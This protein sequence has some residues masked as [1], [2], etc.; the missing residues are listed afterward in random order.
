MQRYFI[1]ENQINNDI[2]TITNE[3]VHHI[4]TVMRMRLDDKIIAVMDNKLFQCQLINIGS[5]VEAK[6]IEEISENNELSVNVT[7]AQGLVRREKTEEVIRRI[8]ELGASNYIPVDMKRSVVKVKEGKVDR[9]NKIIKEASEQSHRNRLMNVSDVINLKEL[10]KEKPKY[11]LCLFAHVDQNK[12]PIE[13]Y[14]NEFLG[15]N[16][17]ILV[18]PEGGFDPTEVKLLLNNGFFMVSLGNLILRTETAPLYI[19]SII[20]NKFGE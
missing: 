18:G 16:I 7:I 6:I 14:L 2:I 11:D 1:N 10:I 8:T 3:D 20:N 5:V 19:M 17:L 13:G 15:K 12:N 4:K 9:W